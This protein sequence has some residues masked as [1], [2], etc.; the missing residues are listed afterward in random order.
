[1]T[2]QIRY[3]RNGDVNLAYQV[4]GSG[5]FDLVFVPGFV[6]HQEVM[7]DEPGAAR[8]IE[9]L[10]PFS[11]LIAYD[12]RDQGLSD[13]LARPPTLEESMEDLRAVLD[14]AGSERAALLGISEGG[15]MC[16]LFAAT[17]PERTKA[18]LL[19]GTYPRIV[20][21]PGFQI[22]VPEEVLDEMGEV[23]REDWGGPVAIDLFAPG[24]AED[25]R[26]CQWWARLLRSGTSPQGAMALM[27]LYRRIDTR[28]VLGSIGV[29]TLVLQRAGDLVAP[30]THGRYLAEHIPGARYVEFPGGDHV[31]TAGDQ[32]ALLDEVEEFLTGTRHSGTDRVP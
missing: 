22:G 18:L 7:W 21:A 11:R 16:Q 2:G 28:D 6:S 8:F 25:E 4:R 10:A 9:R 13:R 19:C 27:D 1:M 5:P 12:K 24:M 14:A 20:E 3:A 17:F 23:M 30:V 32:E 31:P 26:F 15:P 29:P